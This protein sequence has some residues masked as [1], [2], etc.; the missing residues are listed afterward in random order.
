MKR[1]ICQLFLLGLPLLALADEPPTF[2]ES[3][4]GTNKNASTWIV[5]GHRTNKIAFVIFQTNHGT[6]T[7]YLLSSSTLC[8]VTIF[9]A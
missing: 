6:N 8:Y 2:G 1:I 3:F 4:G 5:Y 7:A 9:F